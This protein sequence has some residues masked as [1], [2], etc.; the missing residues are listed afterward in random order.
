MPGGGIHAKK[1]V[2]RFVA[3]AKGFFGGLLDY[4]ADTGSG[5]LFDD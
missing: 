1:A 3:A 4:G 2:G 5:V